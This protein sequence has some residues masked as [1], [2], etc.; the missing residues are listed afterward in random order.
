[1]LLQKMDINQAEIIMVH[2]E[3]K[4]HLWVNNNTTEKILE[5]KMKRDLVI[6]TTGQMTTLANRKGEIYYV[7]MKRYINTKE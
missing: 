3:R 6:E 1:M 5:N 4:K 2:L 7:S